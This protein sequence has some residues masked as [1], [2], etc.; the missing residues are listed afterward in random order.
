MAKDENK[1]KKAQDTQA[2]EA[3]LDKLFDFQEFN[4]GVEDV[5]KFEL[6]G[7]SAIGYVRKF[8]SMNTTKG[9]SYF[10]E[11]NP[12][13]EAGNVIMNPETEEPLRSTIFLSAGLLNYPWEEFMNRAVRI[14]YVGEQLNPRS[15]QTF[16]CFK[17]QVSRRR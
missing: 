9:K 17:V 1:D 4:I 5:I 13:D 2:P 8:S 11:I 12:I 14:E 6:E 7:D 15:G 16:K 10:I 3:D